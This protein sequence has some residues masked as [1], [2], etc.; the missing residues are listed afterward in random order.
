SEND[1]HYGGDREA[2]QSASQAHRRRFNEEL[3]QDGPAF[4][5]DGFADA[6]FS[7]SFG[8]RDEHDVHDTDA[9]HEERQAG[10]EDTGA[11]NDHAQTIETA[12]EKFHGVDAEIVIDARL[13]AAHTAHHAADFLLGVVDGGKGSDLDGDAHAGEER[14]SPDEAGD[15]D[16]NGVV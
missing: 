13:Q 15:W 16:V 8:H 9:A 10:D 3:D 12:D 7:R 11:A 6:D 4:G 1:R 5:A 2:D 14:E